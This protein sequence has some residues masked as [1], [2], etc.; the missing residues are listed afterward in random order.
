[1]L[2]C[3]IFVRTAHPQSGAPVQYY[4]DDLGR[5]TRVVDPS[6][7][8]VT[9][10]RPAPPKTSG[11]KRVDC[12]HAGP[13]PL[14]EGIQPEAGPI[15]FLVAPIGGGIAGGM[16]ASAEGLGA[17]GAA[18][19]STAYQGYWDSLSGRA[20]VQSSPYN[21]VLQYDE[22]GNVVGATTYDQFGNRAYQ[23]EFDPDV[24][25]G[26]GYH[27]YDNSGPYIGSGNGPR[28]PHAPF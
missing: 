23:Y 2:T 26:A 22:D 15:L 13:T 14:C 24:R 28:S 12:E 25:H 1:M 6:G 18:S 19:D 3:L 4:Y 16:E 21:I 17:E 11:R 27:A 5:L 9:I 8:I 10:L 7:N 20:R